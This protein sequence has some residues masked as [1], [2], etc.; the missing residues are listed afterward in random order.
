MRHLWVLVPLALLLGCTSVPQPA[1]VPNSSNPEPTSAPSTRTQAPAAPASTSTAEPTPVE[2]TTGGMDPVLI[3]CQPYGYTAAP[4]AFSFPRDRLT[5]AVAEQTAVALYR[6]CSSSSETIMKLTANT[7][8]GI[9]T[10]G[11][12]NAGQPVWAV[13]IEATVAVRGGSYLSAY[14]VE[15][16]Q[17]TGVPTVIAYG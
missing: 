13:K 15:V 2:S 10:P 16:N 3:S 14:W 9:G 8:A 5:S 6:G 4:I 11:G 7:E 12:P 17:T 1:S